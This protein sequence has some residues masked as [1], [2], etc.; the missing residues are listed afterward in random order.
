MADKTITFDTEGAREAAS[1]LRDVADAS[2]DAG[3]GV[4]DAGKKTK[5]AA[6]STGSLTERLAKAAAAYAAFKEVVVEGT[7]QFASTQAAL[8]RL[9]RSFKTNGARVDQYRASIEEARKRS[10]TLGVSFREQVAGLSQL[11]DATGNAT[12]ANQDLA[13]AIDIA[14]QENMDLT[15]AIEV[16]RKARN[17]EVEELKNL[18]GINKERSAALAKIPGD[19]ERARV[20][21]E[22]LKKAYSGAAEENKGL[23]ER[24]SALGESAGR[25]K[26]SIGNLTAAFIEDGGLIQ[27]LGET[28]G[29]LKDGEDPLAGWARSM[30]GL[31]ED[32]RSLDPVKLAL[33][34]PRQLGRT[35]GILDDAK[36]GPAPSG[37]APS[38]IGTVFGTQEPLPIPGDKPKKKPKKKPKGTKRTRPDGSD[39][40]VVESTSDEEIFGMLAAED[41]ARR[42]QK[43]LA[44]AR[45]RRRERTEFMREMDRTDYEGRQ[46]RFREHSDKMTEIR[47]QAAKARKEARQAELKTAMAAADAAGGIAQTL[48]ENEGARLA[49]QSISTAA[50]AAVLFAKGLAPPDPI[51]GSGPQNLPGAVAMA[52]A[53]VELG[54]AAAKA[55]KGGGVT[56][57]K[58]GGGGGSGARRAQQDV[59]LIGERDRASTAQAPRPLTV[60]I[61]SAFPPSP[62]QA[63]QLANAVE[64]DRRR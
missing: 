48:I 6:E 54:I 39:A 35:L 61:N 16:L 17:G 1:D 32:I 23:E 30:N 49:I 62:E 63:S 47:E 41:E 40:V 15:Q 24:L 4:E 51:T 13:L 55:G 31:A 33:L 8:G 5:G 43:A 2:R 52:G 59:G 38:G 53:A 9:E 27:S 64:R 7:K 37:T 46:Q 42:D 10:V 28:V 11:I 29:I 22:A 36:E 21:I 58:G 3:D 19:T 25:V 56:S 34:G 45:E 26:E 57:K 12:T 20:A 14:S 18:N 60:N 50:Q 44:D